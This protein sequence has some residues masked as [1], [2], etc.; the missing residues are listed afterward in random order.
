M[1]NLPG[2]GAQDGVS[3]HLAF[4]CLLHLANEHGLALDTGG[5]LDSLAIRLPHA[6]A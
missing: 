1:D 5:R 4:I 3:V 6:V 2:A